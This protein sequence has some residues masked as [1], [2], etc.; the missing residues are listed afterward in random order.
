VVGALCFVRKGFPEKKVDQ[1]QCYVGF[2]TGALAAAGAF[3]LNGAIR[4]FSNNAGICHFFLRRLYLLIK[5]DQHLRQ[6]LI[7]KKILTVSLI[8]TLG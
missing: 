1:Q 8:K 5:L 7:A 4:T 2:V 6:S 3:S